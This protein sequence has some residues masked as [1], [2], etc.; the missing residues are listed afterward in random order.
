MSSSSVPLLNMD[1]EDSASIEYY[2]NI[3]TPGVLFDDTWYEDGRDEVPAENNT[4]EA[5]NMA[6]DILLTEIALRQ[7]A[8][9]CIGVD[10]AAEAVTPRVNIIRDVVVKKPRAS[11]L[12]MM[13]KDSSVGKRTSNHPKASTSAA[14]METRPLSP[15]LWSAPRKRV[16]KMPTSVMKA[17][18]PVVD[19]VTPPPQTQPQTPAGDSTPEWIENFSQQDVRDA[20]SIIVKQKAALTQMCAEDKLLVREYEKQLEVLQ[21]K[22]VKV[23]ERHEQNKSKLENIKKNI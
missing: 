23:R 7:E 21:K 14:A 9:T 15:I 1:F 4:Q 19:L 5:E 16:K 22:I 3:L 11:K 13:L 6:C 10:E 20:F 12:K 17:A 2:Q 18:I 8:E